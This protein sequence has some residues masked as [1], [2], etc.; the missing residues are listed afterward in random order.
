MAFVIGI[1]GGSGCGKT[2]AIRMIQERLEGDDITIISQDDYYHP[3]ERQVRDP[4]GVETDVADLIEVAT[5]IIISL[6]VSSSYLFNLERGW[7]RKEMIREKTNRKQA[8]FLK[9]KF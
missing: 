5:K 9:S 2:T 4:K 3:I 1:S 8:F 6:C 7:N